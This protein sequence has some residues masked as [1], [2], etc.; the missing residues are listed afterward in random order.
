MYIQKL[1]IKYG[2]NTITNNLFYNWR[3]WVIISDYREWDIHVLKYKMIVRI[4]K[5]RIKSE[6]NQSDY[7]ILYI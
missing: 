7:P 5:N 6:N 1:I 2:R 4:D 3:I